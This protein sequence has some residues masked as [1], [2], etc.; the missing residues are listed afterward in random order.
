VKVDAD[1]MLVGVL[2][3]NEHFD[4]C[5]CNPPF[6]GSESETDSMSKA[7]SPH[8]EP[9]KNAPTGSGSELVVQGGELE[10]VKRIITDSKKLHQSIR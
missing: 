3:E 10:F 1:Q 8:R 2:P 6:F 4:F 7:R 9:P 5:M